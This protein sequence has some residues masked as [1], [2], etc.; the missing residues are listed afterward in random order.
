MTLGFVL[1]RIFL[2]VWAVDTTAQPVRRGG[3]GFARAMV[4]PIYLRVPSRK[5]R[6]R[7]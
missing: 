5:V 1:S 7:E 2:R 4:R 6:D 3:N